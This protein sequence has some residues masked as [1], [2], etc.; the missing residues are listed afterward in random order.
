MIDVDYFCI[1]PTLRLKNPVNTGYFVSII[2]EKLGI[3]WNPYND[4]TCWVLERDGELELS[5]I[6]DNEACNKITIDIL[7]KS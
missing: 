1:I 5:I 2:Y 7:C 3:K 4:N 6:Y